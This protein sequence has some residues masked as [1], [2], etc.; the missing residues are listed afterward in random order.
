[1]N[2]E[3]FHGYSNIDFAIEKRKN[4]AL[5]NITVSKVIPAF[6]CLEVAL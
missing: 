5:K 1:M 6:I 4:R 2:P 3:S